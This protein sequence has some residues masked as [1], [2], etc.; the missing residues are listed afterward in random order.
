MFAI[1]AI[2]IGTFLEV[3][4]YSVYVATFVRHVRILVLRRKLP[5]KVFIF[6]ST[7]S[8]L[9]F[10]V[11]TV[12]MVADLIFATNIFKNPTETI[13]FSGYAKKRNIKIIC[14][15]LATVVSD[16]VLLYRSYI[17][18]DSRLRVV[19]LPLLVFVVQCGTGIWSLIS[20]PQENNIDP[21][22]DRSQKLTIGQVIFGFISGAEHEDLL[23][24]S[25]GLIIVCM[26]RSHRRLLAAGIPNVQSL[27]AYVRVGALMINSA[28][29]NIVWWISVFVTST[30]SSLLYEVCAAPFACVTALIFSAIIVSASR[31]PSS[32]SF[33]VT[34]VSFPSRA[35]PQGS[36]PSMDLVSAND[37]LETSSAQL[38]G[39]S[40]LVDRSN[41]DGASPE[42][43]V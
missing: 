43:T 15:S 13:D 2:F 39:S 41:Y 36:M 5:P 10:V 33:R 4:V 32:E 17:L 37:I 26:W 28:A 42:E 8:L 23:E 7:A 9:L 14:C 11:A 40:P 12:T 34:P 22:S 35:F 21:W 27:S 1:T 16:T 30:I 29:I 6:L 24:E 25:K 19:A 38:A 31:P 18:Y 20:L 3:V